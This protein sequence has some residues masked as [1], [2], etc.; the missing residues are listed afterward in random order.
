MPEVGLCLQQKPK[1][2]IAADLPIERLAHDMRKERLEAIE[3]VGVSEM[4]PYQVERLYQIPERVSPLKKEN[5]LCLYCWTELST[6]GCEQCA[7]AQYCS[8]EH[9]ER[10]RKFHAKGCVANAPKL[11]RK[12]QNSVVAVFSV[13]KTKLSA[14]ERLRI[15]STAFSLRDAGLYVLNEIVISSRE[16]GHINYKDL[17]CTWDQLATVDMSVTSAD[18]LLALE[19]GWTPNFYLRPIPDHDRPP[20]HTLP[21]MWLRHDVLRHLVVMDEP[22]SCIDAK[23]QEK[24]KKHKDQIKRTA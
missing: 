14:I 2:I 22:Q 12:N 13:E 10:D 8:M 1:E 7:I 16:L 18:Y 23:E 11:R 3:R 17:L 5:V 21:D 9:L 19:R 15:M 24:K 4:W 6:V 20:A